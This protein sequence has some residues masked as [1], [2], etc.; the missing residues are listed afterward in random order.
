MAVDFGFWP[1][2]LAHD[3]GSTLIIVAWLFAF[4][5]LTHRWVLG[6]HMHGNSQAAVA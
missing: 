1:A 2:V 4:W 3:Y 6:N 5:A